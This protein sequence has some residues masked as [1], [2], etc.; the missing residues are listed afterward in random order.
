[1]G[2]LNAKRDW[3]YASDYVRA[4]WLMLQQSEP[5]DYVI[6]TGKT[7]SVKQ[8][9][10]EAFGYLDLNWEKH[11]VVDKKYVR[12]VDVD[13]LVG[14]YSKAKANLGWEPLVSFEELVRIMVDEDMKRLEERVRHGLEKPCK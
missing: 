2:N 8:L 12:P 9:V 7:H 13:V 14:D 1:M 4:M 11:V 6:A 5:D 3:G 10:E